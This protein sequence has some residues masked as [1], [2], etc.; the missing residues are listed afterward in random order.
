MNTDISKELDE[1]LNKLKL[2]ITKP[3]VMLIGGTGVG[4]SSLLNHCFGK[5]FAKT[6]VGKPVTQHL[7]KFQSDDF[8]IVIYD[9]KG[10]EIGGEQEQ[11]FFKD[12]I[13]F[14]TKPMQNVEEAIH[15][16]WYCITASGSR[17]T[18]FDIACIKK[19]QAANL[20]TAIVLT[21]SDLISDEDAV[22]FRA[23]IS[24]HLPEVVVYEVSVDQTLNGLQLSAL[25]DW[26]ISNLS[27][28]LKTAFIS[29]QKVNLQ[30]KKAQAKKAI[31][32][33]SLGSA[34]IG[35]SPIP[36][37]DA[38]LIVANQAALLARIL[39]IYSLDGLDSKFSIMIK[40]TTATLLPMAGRYL[41]VQILKFIPIV[42][43]AVG[44]MINAAIASSIT[45]AFGTAVSELC[46]KLSEMMLQGGI[47][48]VNEYLKHLDEH[49]M[50]FF[51]QAVKSVGKK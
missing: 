11:E 10:Y 25:I 41:S 14:A 17:I 21:K 8:P 22:A 38:P 44:G 1:E 9:T 19:M 51:E 31:Q 32:Q 50:Q 16:V 45:F 7:E 39:Y 40:A 49:F 18:D 47:D 13:G 23:A 35:F 43:T 34:T 36:F 12:V 42:G 26:S 4:K 48:A 15:L 46:A 24:A 28:G 5:S 6:G 20:P 33:H 30:A 27:D 37:S 3:N 2:S 29:A